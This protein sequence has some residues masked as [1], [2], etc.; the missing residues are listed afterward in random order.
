MDCLMGDIPIRRSDASNA[1]CSK[2]HACWDMPCFIFCVMSEW[3]NDSELVSPYQSNCISACCKVFS[4][5]LWNLWSRCGIH[6]SCDDQVYGGP[7]I[8]AFHA[9]GVKLP[10]LHPLTWA[11]DLL[12]AKVCSKKMLLWLCAGCGLSGRRGTRDVMVRTHG[13]RVRRFSGREIRPWTC[14]ISCILRSRR[15]RLQHQFGI[16]NPH[17]RAGW[18]VTQMPHTTMGPEQELLERY[19][20]M[21]QVI[22]LQ[23]RLTGYHMRWMS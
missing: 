16:G 8:L 14:G 11:H 20:G 5:K 7:G 18:S 13:R 9:T 21:K 22:I 6:L 15:S 3:Q 10:D 4:F 17:P 19:S 2:N 23:H 12:D 1:D